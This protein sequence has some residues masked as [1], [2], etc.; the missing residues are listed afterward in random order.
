MLLFNLQVPHLENLSL[1]YVLCRV[2][3]RE[4]LNVDKYIQ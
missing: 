2:A 3:Q 1:T 4:F